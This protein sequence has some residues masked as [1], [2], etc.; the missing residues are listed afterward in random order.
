MFENCLH[1][2]CDSLKRYFAT[3][4]PNA[5]IEVDL[6]KQVISLRNLFTLCRKIRLTYEVRTIEKNVLYVQSGMV[7]RKIT[8]VLG[9]SGPDPTLPPKIFFFLILC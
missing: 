6:S 4:L 3:F 5:L 2:I 1:N 9:L 7:F 8:Q